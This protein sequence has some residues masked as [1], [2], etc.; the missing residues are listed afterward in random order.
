ML[1]NPT[2]FFFF[3]NKEQELRQSRKVIKKI[4]TGSCNENAVKTSYEVSMLIAKVGKI[5]TIAEELILP[6]AKAMVSAMVGEKA[7]KDLNLVALSNDKLRK[8]TDKISDNVKQLI[9]R[10]CKS[11]NYRLQVDESTDFANK[12]HL[13]CYVRYEFEG[14]IIEDLLF[15]RSLI[16][17]TAEEVYN[18]LDEFMTSSGIQRSKCVGISTDGS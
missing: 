15:C 3:K 16:H 5:H 6:A 14:K 12:S 2:I 11:Q 8:R 18:S 9:E 10:I 17:T 13:V 7:A 4:T 1:P